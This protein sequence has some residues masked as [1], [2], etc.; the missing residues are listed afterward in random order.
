MVAAIA[1][2]FLPLGACYARKTAHNWKQDGTPD[3]PRQIK[4][5]LSLT[6]KINPLVLIEDELSGL[7]GWVDN[8]G[9][10]IESLQH[11]G[12]LRAQIIRGKGVSLPLE[13]VVCVTEVLSPG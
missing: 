5:E 8:E 6:Q 11:D 3:E 7:A 4:L 1:W 9:V 2:C 13:P 12:V 10:P